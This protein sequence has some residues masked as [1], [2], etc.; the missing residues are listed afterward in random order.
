MNRACLCL[1]LWYTS[2]WDSETLLLADP[3]AAKKEAVIIPTNPV[4]R[5][6]GYDLEWRENV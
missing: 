4:V 2:S 1:I 6:E 3:G 5:K